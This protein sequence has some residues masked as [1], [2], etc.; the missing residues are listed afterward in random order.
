M[1]LACMFLRGLLPMKKISFAEIQC[2]LARTLDRIG[3]WWAP[4]IVRSIYLEVRRFDDLIRDL[5][6]SRNLLTRRLNMMVENGV[7][8]RVAYQEKP[9]RY[10]YRLTEAGRDLVP[11]I[12][13]LTAWGDK[14]AAPAEGKPMVPL[15]NTCGHIFTPVVTCSEC[16]EPVTADNMTILPGPGGRQMPGTMVVAERLRDV[17]MAF[18]RSRASAA[19]GEGQS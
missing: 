10:E 18:M 3:D 19:K 14:W 7:L 6:I 4:L 9:A 12:L 17:G 8:E 11:A 16:G 2:S 13:A 15:H 1:Q 5:G